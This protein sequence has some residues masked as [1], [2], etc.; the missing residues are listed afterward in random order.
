MKYYFSELDDEHCKTL[1]WIKVDMR[2]EGLTELEVTE[3]K[4]I[5]G[6]KTFYCKN[7]DC[8]MEK[9]F[10]GVWCK[11]YSPRN[12]K[13]GRCRYSGYC[14]EPTDKKRIIRLKP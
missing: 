9:D 8:S 1:K 13:S 7:C 3:A 2:E 14:Y 10:C 4:R 11:D 5:T 6:Q 12:H